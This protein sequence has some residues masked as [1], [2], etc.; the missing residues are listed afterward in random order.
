M[1]I[2]AIPVTVFGQKVTQVLNRIDRVLS[3]VPDVVPVI[4]MSKGFPEMTLVG[5]CGFGGC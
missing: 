1:T 5:W 2:L 3:L 4:V